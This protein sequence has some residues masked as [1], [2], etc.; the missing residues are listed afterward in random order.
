MALLV[1]ACLPMVA[2]VWT[3]ALWVQALL[4]VWAISW[5]RVGHRLIERDVR[6]GL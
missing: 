6:R 5:T 1:I 3:K 2:L 4:A